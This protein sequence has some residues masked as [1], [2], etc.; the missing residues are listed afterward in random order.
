MAF[1]CKKCKKVFRKDM[2][3]YEESD[4]FCPHCDN[5]YVSAVSAMGSDGRALTRTC[6]W[7]VI[8]AKI[9]QAVIGVEGEDARVDARRVCRSWVQACALT[10]RISGCSRTSV[11]DKTPR[12][13][14][15]DGTTFQ[16]C[17]A[18]NGDFPFLD[19]SVL[20]DVTSLNGTHFLLFSATESADAPLTVPFISQGVSYRYCLIVFA[21]AFQ[22]IYPRRNHALQTNPPEGDA[23]ITIHASNWLFA[24]FAVMLLSW[25]TTL[26]WT[27][28]VCPLFPLLAFFLIFS[29]EP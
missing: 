17:W 11:R 16:M 29:I 6:V 18:E 13:P 25:F 8:E 10:C 21:M 26:A 27:F 20:R 2:S 9:P 15:F 19:M 4:E 3:N 1:A 14:S 24:V 5:H 22:L 28:S 23:H 7:Q 12:G